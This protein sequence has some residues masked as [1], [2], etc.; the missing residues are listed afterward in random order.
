MRLLVAGASGRTGRLLVSR[1]LARGHEVTA[2]V[3][4]PSAF[5][6]PVR[7]LR[8]VVG[9]VLEPGTLSAA[10][11]G[12][13]A[14]VSVI[15][16][17]PRKNGRVYIEGTRALADAAANAGV[18]RFVAVSAEGAG[19]KGTTVPFLYRLVMRIPVV[20]RLYPDIARMEDELRARTDVDWTIVRP[21]I[22]TNQPATGTFRTVVGPVVPRG[23]AISRADLAVFLLD[24]VEGRRHVGEVVAV[25]D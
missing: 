20:A 5:P 24:T 6:Q 18:R 7:S 22:L 9:D 12:Q 25:A 3:R 2:L 11:A 23:L 15:A 13:D 19:A 17:R 21:A 10:V 8:V 1:A 14:I 16:P 4:D